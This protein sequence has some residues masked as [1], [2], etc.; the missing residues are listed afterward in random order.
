MF[1][2]ERKTL[3]GGWSPTTA[4]NDPRLNDYNRETIRGVQEVKLQHEL[5][6]LDELREIYGYVE[7]AVDPEPP[8]DAPQEFNQGTYVK[9]LEQENKAMKEELSLVKAQLHKSSTANAMI[10]SKLQAVLSE[11]MEL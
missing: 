3:I 2:Y 6:P 7:N 9:V 4:A 11:Y 5:L 1:Y 8:K 10:L